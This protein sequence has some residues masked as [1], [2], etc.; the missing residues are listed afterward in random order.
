[1][2]HT[3]KAKL[4][5]RGMLLDHLPLASMRSFF[6]GDLRAKEG[7]FRAVPMPIPMLVPCVVQEL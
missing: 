7:C 2:P 4:I 1:V 5:R 3:S 6:R